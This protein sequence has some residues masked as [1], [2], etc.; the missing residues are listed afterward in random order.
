MVTTDSWV[1]ALKQERVL[2]VN[3]FAKRQLGVQVRIP[4]SSMTKVRSLSDFEK[5]T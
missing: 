5:G 3:L 2:V 1:I 4:E